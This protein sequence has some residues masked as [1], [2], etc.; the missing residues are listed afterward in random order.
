MV[1]SGRCWIDPREHGYGPVRARFLEAVK[2]RFDAEG[3]DMPY[4]TTEL[5]GGVEVTEVGG[6]G[7]ATG[8]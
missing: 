8:D 5:T 7:T 1:L 4:P 6:P 2:E 3:I